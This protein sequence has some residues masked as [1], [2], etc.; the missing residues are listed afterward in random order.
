MKYLKSKFGL[1]SLALL[2]LVLGGCLISG[3]FIV[4][5]VIEF[6]SAAAFYKDAVDLTGNEE[7]EDH[8][9]DIDRIDVVGFELWMTNPGSSFTLDAYLD[10]PNDTAYTTSGQVTANTTHVFGSF[11]VPGGISS[12][13]RVVS[14]SNSFQYLKNVE[15][16]RT[17]VKSGAFDF[18]VLSPGNPGGSL[19]SVRVV[20]TVSASIPS[21]IL[22]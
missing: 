7:W 14:Y 13:Q 20:I 22:V 19:D 2:S 16:I 4:V 12:S 18:Y 10:E 1:L 5:Q 21:Y 15:A 3:T 8:K 9:D 6:G 17:L 11:T